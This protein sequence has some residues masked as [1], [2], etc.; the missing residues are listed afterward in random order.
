MRAGNRINQ[1]RSKS[2]LNPGELSDVG[3]ALRTFPSP[4]ND[5]SIC[6]LLLWS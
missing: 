6:A 3:S 5:L 2:R 1:L 4:M